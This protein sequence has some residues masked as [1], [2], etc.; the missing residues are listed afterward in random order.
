M[1]SKV[2]EVEETEEF[3]QEANDRA[4]SIWKCHKCGSSAEMTFTD[5]NDVGSPICS[6]CDM[7]M[8]MVNVKIKPRTK[9][10]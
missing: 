2:E 4:V 9:A 3:D 8:E 6:E 7:D 1:K 5:M 10:N